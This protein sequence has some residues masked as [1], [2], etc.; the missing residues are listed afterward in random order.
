MIENIFIREYRPLQRIHLVKSR[1]LLGDES[2]EEAKPADKGML[3]KG[4]D[5]Q[6]G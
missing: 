6:T 3:L 4:M 5:Q 2:Y 1:H